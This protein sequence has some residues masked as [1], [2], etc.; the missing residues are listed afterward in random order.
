MLWLAVLFSAST[1]LGSSRRTSRF[2]LPLLRWLAPD[3]PAS[4]LQTVQFCV[5]KTGHAVG[6]ALLAGLVWRARRRQHAAPANQWSR[7]DAAF[8]F[9]TATLFAV[10]DEWHQTFTATRQ[11]AVADVALDAAGAALGLA[12]IWLWGRW[13]RH[14]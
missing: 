6:Y 2:L 7:A 3:L 1:E 4:T 14:W 13:R 12:A 11:G 8:A 9:G 10:T 5:R